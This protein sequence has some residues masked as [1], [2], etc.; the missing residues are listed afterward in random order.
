MKDSMLIRRIDGKTGR[1]ELHTL[2][3]WNVINGY[4]KTDEIIPVTETIRGEVVGEEKRY[5]HMQLPHTFSV[6]NASRSEMCKIMVDEEEKY[7]HMQSP[8]TFSV[9]DALRAE[10]CKLIVSDVFGHTGKLL[11]NTIKPNKKRKIHREDLP[12]NP[13]MHEPC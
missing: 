7:R 2:H 4:E 11:A 3:E 12:T 10:F 13:I 1:A 6:P 9:H 5:E 8:P